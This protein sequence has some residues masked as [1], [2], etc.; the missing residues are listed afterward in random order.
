[1]WS[2]RPAFQRTRR[3]SSVLAPS[4]AARSRGVSPIDGGSGDALTSDSVGR[5]LAPEEAGKARVAER[6]D[7]RIKPGATVGATGIHSQV[8]TRGGCRWP[9]SRGKCHA[10][11]YVAASLGIG[12]TRCRRASGPL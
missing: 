2:L 12:D 10:L 5:R 4:V 7:R 9:F 8:P 1:M 11:A 3:A 6:R